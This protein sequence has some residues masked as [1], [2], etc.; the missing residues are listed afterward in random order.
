MAHSF[1]FQAE[2]GIRDATVT[3]VQTCALPIYRGADTGGYGQ[4]EIP[5]SG[6]WSFQPAPDR[7]AADRPVPPA[8]F[9]G[10]TVIPR[11]IGVP[12]WTGKLIL[13]VAVTEDLD[14]A[15]PPA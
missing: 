4:Q 1:F 12:A 7:A 2:D 10:L 11:V 6:R 14:L 15:P 5:G 9:A 3:G 8:T 13:R